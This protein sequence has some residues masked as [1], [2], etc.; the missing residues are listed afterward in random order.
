[1]GRREQHLREIVAKKFFVID[2]T[3]NYDLQGYY[4]NHLIMKKC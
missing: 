1:M 2:E 4:T 3:S